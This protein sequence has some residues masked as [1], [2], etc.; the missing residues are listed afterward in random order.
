VVF[1]NRFP[2]LDSGAAALVPV[3]AEFPF[4]SGPGV[5]RCEV[6][7]FTSDHNTSFAELPL[8]RVRTV[9]DAWID[10]TEALGALSGVEYVF[11]FENRG[12]EIGVTLS[13]RHGQIY[14]YPFVPPRFTKVVDAAAAHQAEH[15][16]CLQ[17]DIA[18]AETKHGERV[19]LDSE[20]FLV[21]VPFAARWPYEARIVPTGTFRTCPR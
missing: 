15:G 7:C 4:S 21:Y 11:A 17:C 2:P 3:V 10:R 20:H 9:V 12:E 19:V 16:S 18:E 6:V 5:G 8:H 13:H 14:G 1:E